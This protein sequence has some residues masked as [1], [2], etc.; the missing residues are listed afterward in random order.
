MTTGLINLQVCRVF[1]F[2]KFIELSEINASGASY[3]ARMALLD[4]PGL[5]YFLT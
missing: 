4:F 5:N 1:M 3:K 2:R